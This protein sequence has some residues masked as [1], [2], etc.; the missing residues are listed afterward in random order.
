MKRGYVVGALVVLTMIIA[1]DLFYINLDTK[2][3]D[4]QNTATAG[5]I[6]EI[7]E[8]AV[9]NAPASPVADTSFL[10]ETVHTENAFTGWKSC[11]PKHRQKHITRTT[12]RII[13]HTPPKDEGI[14][15]ASTIQRDA[16]PV[17]FVR[18]YYGY[19][20]NK[21]ATEPKIVVRERN[22]LFGPEIGFNWN[23]FYH[24]ATSNIKTG[25]VHAGIAIN[26]RISDHLALQPALR[27]IVK[28]NRVD[29]DI[30]ADIKEKVNLHYISLPA[31]LV[32]KTGKPG[33][34]R[35]L[36]GT[37]PYLAYLAGT[38]HFYSAP[39]YLDV[40]NPPR[41]Y[42]TRYF[43]E[44]DWGINSFI[45]LESP[46]GVYVKAGVE[47][48]LRDIYRNPV[49]GATSDRNYNLLFSVGYL[50]GGTR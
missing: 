35:L 21:L 22:I 50:V 24:N 40:L 10:P 33:N 27:Y 26:V 36:L 30:D 17:T 12:K 2:A 16:A 42:N 49:N 18:D 41:P 15:W 39:A 13:W 3:P 14:H 5:I 11:K 47:Y 20:A 8:P 29:A 37:G 34:M 38:R 4:L 31:N 46:M 25:Y 48:G 7:P 1:V 43:R 28:G 6:G 19:N 45:G 32:Y 23:S 44:I 9:D